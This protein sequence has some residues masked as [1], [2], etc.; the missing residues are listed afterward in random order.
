MTIPRKAGFVRLALC[1]SMIAL[2]TACSHSPSESDAKAVIKT[3][4]ADCD[5]FSLR[6]FDKVNGTPGDD[7]NSYRVDVKYTVR[8]SPDSE[9][10]KM[11]ATPGA[12]PGILWKVHNTCPNVPIQFI[13]EFFANNPSAATEETEKE[14]TQTLSMVKTDNGWQAAR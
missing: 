3:Q 7:E 4:F 5:Y 2:L 11:G 1:A 13:T 10:E 14:F 6:S 8:M 9:I 12:G